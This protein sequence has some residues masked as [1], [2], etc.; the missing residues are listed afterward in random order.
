M[1][2]ERCVI[3]TGGSHGERG[4]ASPPGLEA[5]R[6]YLRRLI[7][8]KKDC[9]GVLDKVFPVGEEGLREIVKA[10]FQ[11]P[12]RVSCLKAAMGTKEGLEMRLQNLD[13]AASE[14]VIGRVRRWSYRKELHRLRQ[15]EQAKKKC[16]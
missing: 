2:S 16:P 9:F 8:L 4:K 1:A 15:R 11:C 14:G 5:I 7:M 13:R 6:F 10:C 12:D 3:L